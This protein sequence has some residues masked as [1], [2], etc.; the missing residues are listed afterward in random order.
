MLSSVR[1]MFIF[2]DI[3]TQIYVMINIDYKFD[4]IKDYIEDNP[5]QLP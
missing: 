3:K 5:L 2:T 1:S 4:A